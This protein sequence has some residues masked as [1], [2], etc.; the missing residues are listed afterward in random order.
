[1]TYAIREK[2][3]KRIACIALSVA[4]MAVCSSFAK[5]AP[6][7]NPYLTVLAAVPAAEMPAKAADVVAQA[8]TPER[9]ATTIAVVQAAVGINPAA[10]P[11][12][13]GAI[14]HA[15]PEMAPLAASTATAQQPAQARAIAKAAAASAP[16]QAA[17][18]VAAVCKIAPKDYQ[19]VASAVAQVAPNA[20]KDIVNAV[21]AALPNL[22][23]SIDKVLSGYHGNVVSVNDTLVQA[24]ATPSS[25]TV[26]TLPTT[27]SLVRPMGVRGPSTGPPYLPLSGTATNVTSGSSGPVPPGD[28]NYAAP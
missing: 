5:D 8:K 6:K 1:M 13:V 19:G 26:S 21:A 23:P 27:T 24:A 25:T 20:N 17:A 18:I 12:I 3:M 2:F 4:C 9:E 11:A 15:V 28:R 10:A 14:A 7:I 16:A 22:K